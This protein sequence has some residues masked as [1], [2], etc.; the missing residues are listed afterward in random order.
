MR[1]NAALSL[2]IDGNTAHSTAFWWNHAAGFY[3]GGTLWIDNG[4]LT[5]NPGRNF[6]FS[7]NRESCAVDFCQKNEN[8]DGYC[9]PAD[10]LWNNITNSKT[11]LTAGTGLNSWSGRWNVVGF[12]SHDSG[13]SLEALA[14]GFWIDNL[15]SVCRTGEPI[16]APPNVD[17]TE[18]R[19]TGFVW[20]D[21]DQ[22]HIIT[23]ATFRNCGLRSDYFI[24]YDSSETRGCSASDALA[25]CTDQSTVFGF[26]AHSDKFNPEVM[27]A[28]ANINFDNCGRRFDLIK[29]TN[30]TTVSGRTQNWLDTDGSVSGLG[31]PTIIGSG[32]K[33]C[34]LWWRVGN[35][36]VE[37]PHG[38]LT[39]IPQDSGPNRAVGH[40]HI[41]WDPPLHAQVD[42]SICGNGDGK[43]CPAIG[44]IRHRGPRFANEP[45][46]PVTAN[47]D[48]AGPVGGFG[49][50]LH[51]DDG[52]PKNLTFSLLEVD[53]NTPL[54]FS[55]SYPVGT[56]FSIQAH[57]AT[58]CYANAN[59][60]CVETFTKVD[61][62]QAVRMSL[63]NTYHVSN[64]GVLTFRVVETSP[65]FVGNPDWFLPSWTDRNIDGTGFALDRFE[66]RGVRLPRDSY[67]P[68]LVVEADC[69]ASGAYCTQSS[70]A[71]NDNV[72]PD[73]F[74]QVSYDTCCGDSACVSSADEPTI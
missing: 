45:G 56:S 38:P 55:I 14:S 21:T 12:E 44:S 54:Y 34:G 40:V 64:D 57:A 65:K 69:P 59:I 10:E 7:Q 72:C 74:E 1:P 43:P 61:S 46:L 32:Y 48:I 42:V 33:E 18:I 29:Y 28:T 50:F 60:S 23:N 25:G 17:V 5:Y 39:F 67:G 49:W 2:K 6:N 8:C 20:Y 53:P 62:E 63:G 66:R 11:F 51:L 35:D 68:Y 31:R 47:A 71:T 4:V 19:G 3:L 52:P 30:Q 9:D 24:D 22:D 13:L 58:W 26:L 36:T 41:E 73:G 37:D 27:Q 70:S 15:I 16:A